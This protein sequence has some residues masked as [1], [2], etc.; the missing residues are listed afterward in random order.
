[1]NFKIP[2]EMRIV[3][4][5]L[6][7]VFFVPSPLFASS[8]IK[9][10]LTSQ[11]FAP[12][13]PAADQLFTR[14]ESE[15]IGVYR[16]IEFSFKDLWPPFWSGRGITSFDM[17]NDGD[18]DLALASTDRGLHLFENDGTGTF[19][20]VD[21][22]LENVK[23]MPVFLVVPIDADNDGWQDLLLT[24]YQT[25]NYLLRNVNGAFH[26]DGI[27]T[28]QNQ[29]DAVLSYAVSAG[30]V[31]KD[32]Y[33]DVVLGNWAAGWY[34]RRP[35]PEASNRVVYNDSGVLDGSK[36][37]ELPAIPSE[38]LSVLLTD[39]DVDGNL[40]LIVAN[41]FIERSDVFYRGDGG[42][43]FVQITRK[44]N[45]IPITTTTSMSMKT[46]DLDQDGTPEIYISQIA[47]RAD[48]ISDKLTFQ[49]LDHYCHGMQNETDRQRCQRNIDYREWYSF[50]GRQVPITEAF[51]C[52]EGTPEFEAV[53]K[54][55]L[56][57]DIAMQRNDP[58][59][60]T[61]IAPDQPRAFLLCEIH[62]RETYRATEAELASNIPEVMGRNV[63]LEKQGDRFVDISKQSGLD[64]GGWSWDVKFMDADLDGDID[65]Y[66]T[67]GH[68][69]I[70]EMSPSNLYYENDGTGLFVG[71]TAERGLEEFMILPS[72]TSS[73]LD[74]DGD[75]D[76][77]GQAVNGPVIAFINNAQNPNRV[78]I[79]FDDEIG[80]RFGIGNRVTLIHGENGSKRQFRELQTGGGFMSFDAPKLYF[81][82][83]DDDAVSA[84]EIVW[85]T[86]ETS[87]IDGPIKPGFMH[88]ITRRKT[89]GDPS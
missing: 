36:F 86:G 20:E 75:R 4:V 62:F 89:E 87:R 66:I 52:Q 28:V 76:L 31:D 33:V 13:S 56:I 57:K 54:A 37:E 7:T 51:K 58:S 48:G 65:V 32:G 21:H 11:A 2:Y 70:N 26:P 10:E 29:Q 17:D 78:G 63:L 43:G 19:K 44:D 49:P 68:W 23:A 59:L 9:I 88:T 77:I 83:G 73:D 53:C 12:I 18:D 24:T 39:F 5:F 22:K 74:N 3:L 55:M 81:G 15:Q 40:D 16:P 84:I 34:R 72:L 41:D 71:K 14:M 82:L 45:L 6:A 27:H 85:S 25:G 60:C 1:M 80:N 35:G 42:G 8:D 38:T 64:I 47:G 46:G 50:G 69:I 79:Q 61:H 67:N 30:D